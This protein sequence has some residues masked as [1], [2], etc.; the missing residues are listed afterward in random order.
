MSIFDDQPLS[1]Q[2]LA[3]VAETA[4]QFHSRPSCGFLCIA[5]TTAEREGLITSYEARML[6]R[7]IKDRIEGRFTLGQ[8]LLSKSYPGATEGEVQREFWRQW[9]A[10]LRAKEEANE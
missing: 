10:E 6:E 7:A 9:I 2:H 3:N 8:Y 4:L 1:N 5:A